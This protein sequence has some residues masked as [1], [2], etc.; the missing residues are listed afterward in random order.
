MDLTDGYLG[1]TL[2]RGVN[3]LGFGDCDLDAFPTDLILEFVGRSMGNLDA[4]VDHDNV[5]GK[6]VGLLEVLRREQQRGALVDKVTDDLPPVSYTH[7]RAHETDS[8]L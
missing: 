1:Q 7:L 5:V 2:D 3:V 6:L 4:V 8:Y